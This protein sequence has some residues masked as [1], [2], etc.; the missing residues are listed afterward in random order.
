[1]GA[2]ALA[3]KP[4]FKMKFIPVAAQFPKRD[5]PEPGVI[6]PYGNCCVTGPYCTAYSQNK[7]VHIFDGSGDGFNVKSYG[8]YVVE[9]AI[10]RFLYPHERIQRVNGYPY[11][12]T[13]LCITRPGCGEYGSTAKIMTADLMALHDFVR[14][15]SWLA[16]Q[17]TLPPKPIEDPNKIKLLKRQ[18][19]SK[20]KIY[21]VGKRG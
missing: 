8:R 4:A 18:D 11:G 20:W 1:M 9:R 21:G 19:T 3:V 6:D 7:V 15:S 16:V 17:G 14:T 2:P 12:I 10:G 13:N 5:I